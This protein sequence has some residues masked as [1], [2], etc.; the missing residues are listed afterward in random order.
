MEATEELKVIPEPEETKTDEIPQKSKTQ[1]K[2]ELSRQRWLQDKEKRKERQKV[3]LFYR[4][5]YI[6]CKV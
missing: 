4:I 6:C 1:I 3:E 2:K 5:S